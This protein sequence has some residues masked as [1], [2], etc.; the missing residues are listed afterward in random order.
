M[1]STEQRP[2][3]LFAHGKESGPWGSKIRHLAEISQGLGAKVLS[4]DYSGIASPDERVAYLLSLQL[5]PHSQLIL[6]GSSMGGYV[7]TVASAKLNPAGLFLMAPAFSLPIYAEQ[8]P[9]PKASAIC[10]VHGWRDEVVPAEHGI[11]FAAQ[12]HA[13]LHVLDADHRLNEVLPIVRLLFER[14]LQPILLASVY[15][16]GASH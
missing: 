1:N 4:P 5:P 16:A 12:H 7:S 8:N 14:F 11:R 3:V 10:V 13:E 2:L 9:V 6:V 15:S